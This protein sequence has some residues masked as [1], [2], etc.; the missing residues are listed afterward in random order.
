MQL[1]RRPAGSRARAGG[2]AQYFP[3]RYRIYPVH[4]QFSGFPRRY[5]V[6]RYRIDRQ[7][8]VHEKVMEITTSEARS[9]SPQLL[10]SSK[11]KM[12]FQGIRN[13]RKSNG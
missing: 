11:S 4:A 3:L 7:T 13:G 8:D 9:G 5:T 1:A 6:I 10:Y 2:A 12:A